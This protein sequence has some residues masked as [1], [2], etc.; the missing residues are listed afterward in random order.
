M[1]AYCDS[2]MAREILLKIPNKEEMSRL[3][4]YIGYLEGKSEVRR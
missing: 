3:A 1:S 4:W 2:E